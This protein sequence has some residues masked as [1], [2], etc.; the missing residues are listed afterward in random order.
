ME[1]EERRPSGVEIVVEAPGELAR[2]FVADLDR[3]IRAAAAATAFTLALPG[4][5]VAERFLPVLAAAA[6]DWSRVAL[7]WA[8]ERAVPPESPESNYG[9]ARRLLL[10][11]AG[12]ATARVH[13]M[14][15]DARDL[16]RAAAE[17]ADIL[18]SLAGEPPALAYVLLGVGEDGHVASLF[19]GAPA[20]DVEPTETVGWTTRAPKPPSRRMTLTFATLARARRVAVAAFGES[21]A[22][23]VASALDGADTPLG[24]LLRVTARPVLFLDPEAAPVGADEAPR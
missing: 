5:S 16:A 24:Q 11:P 7:L 23:A 6:V 12:V 15:A 19:P 4:G 13:R 18:A 17:Y 3:E 22:R 9:L 14:P 21:K 8:D 2:R 20:P 1:R 10:E